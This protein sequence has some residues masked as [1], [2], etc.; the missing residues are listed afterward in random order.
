MDSV[1]NT[2]FQAVSKQYPETPFEV[3]LWDGKIQKY[4]SG[5]PKF[6]LYLRSERAVKH[7]FKA[8]TLGFGE[9]YMDEGIRVEGDLQELVKMGD[10]WNEGRVS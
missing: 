3:I 9:E 5:E 2:I 10:Y 1:L 8:G 4:G 6:K 7:I